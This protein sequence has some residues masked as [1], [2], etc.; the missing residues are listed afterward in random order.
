MTGFGTRCSICPDTP[1]PRAPHHSAAARG[2]I[3]PARYSLARRRCPLALKHSPGVL[4]QRIHRYRRTQ[5]DAGM[6]KERSPA[7]TLRS[8]AG[9]CPTDHR[10]AISG[11]MHRFTWHTTTPA[12]QEPLGGA[13]EPIWFRFH[14]AHHSKFF[15]K[16]N[17]INELDNI[18]E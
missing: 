17:I 7:L 2:G 1:G 5:L 8:Y 10:T 16:L 12:A 13:S 15:I 4:G 11:D 3:V 18:T 14:H 9:R 6:K